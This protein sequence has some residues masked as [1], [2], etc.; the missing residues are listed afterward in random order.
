[1]ANESTGFSYVIKVN[2]G[3]VGSPTWTSVASQRGLSINPVSDVIDVSSKES[4][5]REF[6]GGM[7]GETI[8]FD[9][10]FIRSGVDFAALQTAQRAGSKIQVMRTEG[11]T[12]K[13]WSYALITDMTQDFPYDGPAT[14]SVSLQLTGTWTA[15]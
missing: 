14:I 12:N 11:G 1:M 8:S 10:M 4:L 7:I 2:T 5:H 6:L 9:A 3:T 13:E 15:V